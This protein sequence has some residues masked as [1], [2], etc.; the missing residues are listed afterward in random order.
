[1]LKS[2]VLVLVALVMGFAS[3]SRSDADEV[4]ATTSP[5]ENNVYMS[6]NIDFVDD[7]ADLT[8]ML[9]MGKRHT[10]LEVDAAASIAAPACTLGVAVFPF[11]NSIALAPAMIV[12]RSAGDASRTASSVWWL[13]L[14]WAEQQF[15]GMFIE[16]PLHLT[17]RAIG[18]VSP[19]LGCNDGD[20][21]TGTLRA[22]L[23][24]K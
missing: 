10:V 12:A 22:R 15:P 9:R 11:V 21:F 7:L 5:G 20:I 14:D 23:V 2:A 8:A 6:A 4:F 1:M 3:T 13:D 18:L 16:Q 24:R 19:G 17:L